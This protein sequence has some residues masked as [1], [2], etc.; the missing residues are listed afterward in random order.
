VY[1]AGLLHF[2]QFSDTFGISEED[3]MPASAPLLASFVAHCRKSYEGKTITL[4]LS[5]VQYWHIINQ[6]PCYINS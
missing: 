1:G 5:G 3:C 4:W 2:H 6:A